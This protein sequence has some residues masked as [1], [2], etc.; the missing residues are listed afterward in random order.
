[1]KAVIMAGGEG[2]RLRPVSVNKPKPMATLFGRPVL[3]HILLLLQ[4]NGV[5]EACCTLKYMPQMI[6]E[7]FGSGENFGV[8]LTYKIEEEALGTAGGVSNCAD[9]IGEEDFLVIS[10]DCVCDF[11]LQALFDFHRAKKA[12]ATLA[13]THHKEPLEYGLVVTREDGRVERFVEKPAW[14]KVLTDRI[15]TGIYV[16]SPTVLGEIP[17]G[18][19]YD[20]GRDLFPRLLETNSALYGFDANGYWCDIGSPASYLACC[21]DALGSKVR[22]DLGAPLVKDGVWCA[23]PLPEGVLIVP[24]VVIGDGAVIDKGATIGPEAVIGASSVV[25]AGAVVCRA[26]VSGAILDGDVHLDGAIVCRGA[27][28]GRG[29]VVSEGAVIGEDC[30]VGEHCVLAPGTKLWPSRQIVSGTAV[31]GTLSFGSL[32]S[33][34]TFE[35]PGIL[36]GE[37]MLDTETAL[38]LGVASASFGR[39]GV[40]WHG[41]DGARVLAEAFGCGVSSGGAALYR[42]DSAFRAQCA[43]AGILYDLPLTVFAEETREGVS[44]AFFSADGVVIPREIERKLESAASDLGERPVRR[45]GVVISG[46]GVGE[47]YV[48]EAARRARADLDVTEALTVAVVGKGAENRAL[49]SALSHLGCIVLDKLL[50]CPAFEIMPGGVSFEA[51]DEDGYRLTADKTAVLSAFVAFDCGAK[52]LAVPYDAPD[53]IDS[54]AATFQ[55]SVRRL[56]RDGAAADALFARQLTLRDGVFDASRLCAYLTSRGETLRDLHRRLPIFHAATREVVLQGDR[57]SVMRALSGAQAGARLEMLAGLRLESEKG[58]VHIAPL[59]HR[60]ALAIRAEGMSE[61]IA[62]ELCAEFEQR[63]QQADDQS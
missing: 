31:S 23:S 42:C 43:Y 50:H 34:P 56:G 27:R 32:K 18:Q 47:A 20:F 17:Q 60:S 6:T 24:P 45:A 15:N 25:G 12:A 51:V 40:A 63:A 62:E 7:Y 8:R 2:T 36:S 52:A 13:L 37:G 57:G 33:G 28:I 58:N 44:L 48:A 54:L 55:G 14:D 16:L 22:L 30:L 59:R 29:T 49:K 19:P 38:R 35:K 11:D 9:F 46:A 53:I 10:G 3:E 4:K 26:V 39:V 5:T 61:E 1:M 41:G 21:R